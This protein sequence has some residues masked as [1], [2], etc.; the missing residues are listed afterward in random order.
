MVAG[1]NPLK[2]GTARSRSTCDEKLTNA[3][4]DREIRKMDD[5]PRH[6]STLGDEGG[7]TVFE[8]NRQSS[9]CETLLGLFVSV[10]LSQ[11]DSSLTHFLPTSPTRFAEQEAAGGSPCVRAQGRQ[12]AEETSAPRRQERCSEAAAH[13]ER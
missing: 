1:T 9:S 11:S 10:K 5:G 6:C 8:K 13:W 3:H 7:G 2:Y 4:D 12:H